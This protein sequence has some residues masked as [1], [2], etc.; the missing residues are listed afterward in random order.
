MKKN[1][2]PSSP[3]SVP[4][5]FKAGHVCTLTSF[6]PVGCGCVVLRPTSK[7]MSGRS[8]NL[9]PLFLGRLRPPKRLTSTSYTYFHQ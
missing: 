6:L 8:V 2:R 4:F 1:G 7:V 5:I 3:N 9:T